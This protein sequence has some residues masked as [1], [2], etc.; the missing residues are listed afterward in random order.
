MQ[1]NAF[2]RCN[3]MHAQ[4]ARVGAYSIAYAPTGLW[5]VGT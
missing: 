2:A 4:R 1:D 3:R 5:V